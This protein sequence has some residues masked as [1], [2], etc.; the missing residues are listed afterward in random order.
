MQGPP[1]GPARQRAYDYTKRCLLTGEFAP[2]ALLSEGEVASALGV[3]RTPVREA[4]LRLESEGLLK[5][6]PK[7]G[8]LV[9]PITA[10][11]AEAVAEARL[12]IERHCADRLRARPEE[13]GRLVVALE[14]MLDQQRRLLEEGDAEAVA[15]ADRQFHHA[16]VQAAGNVVVTGLY[17]SLRDRQ[18]AMALEVFKGQPGRARRSL[19]EHREVIDA[20]AAGG[21]KPL[22]RALEHHVVQVLAAQRTRGP[23]LS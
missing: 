4:F 6:Y 17:D 10:G 23:A 15:R 22:A 20:L 5:L 14:E 19:D 3:S 9:P 1:A 16:I 8:A 18:V 21:G 2:G 11:E 7:R 12:V 13:L